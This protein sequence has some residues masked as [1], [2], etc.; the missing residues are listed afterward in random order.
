MSIGPLKCRTS[1]VFFTSSSISGIFTE[2]DFS[3]SPARILNFFLQNIPIVFFEIKSTYISIPYSVPFIYGCT[4]NWFSL[5][6]CN[7]LRS[8]IVATLIAPTLPAPLLGFTNTSP[9]KLPDSNMSST[10][11]VFI[12]G[13]CRLFKNWYISYLSLHNSTFWYSETATKIPKS[14]NCF[15]SFAINNNSSSCNGKTTFICS[16]SHISNKLFK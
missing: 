11:S 13:I 10:N 2:I 15:L 4:I 3:V 12:V 7:A 8:A 16:F 9:S 14:S 5:S 6:F 1:M